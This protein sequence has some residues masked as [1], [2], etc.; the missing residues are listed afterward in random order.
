MNSKRY[1]L[2]IAILY[3]FFFTPT[4]E[5][6]TSFFYK[7]ANLI[8]G[9]ADGG[10]WK[11]KSSTL[12]NSIGFEGYRRF[13]SEYG[14]YLTVDLQVRVS[15]DSS[16]D[17]EDAWGLEIHNAWIESK[18][19]QGHNVKIGHF[20]PA[21]GLEPVLD[22]HGTILQTLARKNIGFKKDW[23]AAL[24]G[25]L[26]ELDYKVALQLGSGMSIRKKDDIFLITARIGTP[27]SENLQ[28]GVSLMYGE[29]LESDGMRTFPRDDLVSERTIFKRRIG[30]DSQYLFGSYLFKG[31]AA[32]GKDE[33]E[34]VLGYMSEVDYTFPEYQNWRLELQFQSWIND[35]DR[36]GSN[37]T[38]LTA[39]TS[40]NVNE[41]IT[42][43]AAFSHDFN[44]ASGGE[45]DRVLVQFYYYAL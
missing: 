31:E 33:D 23:G 25:A 40:Y 21:F 17:S 45:E 7:E 8:G 22:T 16:E 13:S 5:A 35:L 15:Y 11:G 36:T 30:V 26:S 6:G 1:V 18:L 10:N 39:G 12:R 4:A 37:D 19:A 3:A 42:I 32:F 9:Y 27:T 2:I 14:D 41:D 29:V 20:D 38:T 28:C 43:R 44:L 24:K 34:Y